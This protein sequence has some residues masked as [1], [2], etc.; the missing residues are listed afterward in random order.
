MKVV[1]EQYEMRLRPGL[2][3]WA[4]LIGGSSVVFSLVL[5]CAV[6]FAALA[7]ASALLLPGRAA[8]VL[9]GSA[10]LAN[11]A[12]GYGWLGYPYTLSSLGWGVAIGLAAL[13]ATSV[14]GAFCRGL[15]LRVVAWSAGLVLAF[16]TYQGVLIATSAVLPSGSGAFSP[17]IVG[18]LFVINLVALPG[19]VLLHRLGSALGVIGPLSSPRLAP[20]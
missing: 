19:L 3:L 11:Q 13:A 12:V 2:A 20:A 16:A 8:L 7:T 10:W 5:A 18:Q 1:N 4:V 14:V 17:A 15:S 6:P 9:V